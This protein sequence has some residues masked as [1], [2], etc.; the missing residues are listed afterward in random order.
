MKFIQNY[1]VE[2]RKYPLS[3]LE[4]EREKRIATELSG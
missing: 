4:S 3:Y 2:N 1:F